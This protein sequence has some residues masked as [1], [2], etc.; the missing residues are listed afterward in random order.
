M[1]KLKDIK[2]EEKD[3]KES[4]KWEKYGIEE[5]KE[6]TAVAPIIY[7]VL[8]VIALGCLS[9]FTK[10]LTSLYTEIASFVFAIGGIILLSFHNKGNISE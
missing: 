7:V 8:G 9:W 5:R 3:K 4:K 2:Q 6:K 10:S 1:K